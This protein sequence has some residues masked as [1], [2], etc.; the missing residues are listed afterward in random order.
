MKEA[1]L[2]FFFINK[3]TSSYPVLLSLPCRSFARF[4]ISPKREG[5]LSGNFSLDGPLYFPPHVK[6]IAAS[7]LEPACW[8]IS[9]WLNGNTMNVSLSQGFNTRWM[10]SIKCIL[11]NGRERGT[12]ESICNQASPSSQN[13][14]GLK[15]QK[16]GKFVLNKTT[17][18]TS[19][20][21]HLKKQTCR[22][23]LPA[24]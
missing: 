9:F 1:Y 11:H 2:N 19:K 5:M 24:I 6:E 18:K 8:T 22:W 21:S 4:Y 3:I 23:R 17:F 14:Q 13:S 10:N 12:R 16:I 15:M 7:P 20:L